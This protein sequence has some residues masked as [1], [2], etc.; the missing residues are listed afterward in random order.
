VFDCCLN[1][2]EIIQ[3]CEVV[4]HPFQAQGWEKNPQDLPCSWQCSFNRNFYHLYYDMVD[5]LKK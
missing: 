1:A 2:Q 5:T 3:G 4:Q